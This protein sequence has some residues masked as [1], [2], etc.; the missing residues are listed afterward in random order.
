MAEQ[1]EEPAIFTVAR[2]FL[3]CPPHWPYCPKALFQLRL[4]RFGSGQR[5]TAANV[6][7]GANRRF[8]NEV[9]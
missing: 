1:K 9:D 5:G 2:I 3:G 7:S 4:R 8:Y 6:D